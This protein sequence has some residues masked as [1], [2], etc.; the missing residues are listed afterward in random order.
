MESLQDGQTDM[1][2]PMTEVCILKKPLEFISCSDSQE[3]PSLAPC[4]IGLRWVHLAV[5]PECK[6]AGA[7][8]ILCKPISV[9]LRYLCSG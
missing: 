1:G 3:I 5:S 7:S 6:E 4:A 9:S 2:V 8:Q